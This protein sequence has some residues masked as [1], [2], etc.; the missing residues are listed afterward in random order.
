MKTAFD[1]IEEAI[2][3]SGWNEDSVIA[4]LCDYI[5]NQQAND[6]FQDFIVQRIADEETAGDEDD[7]LREEDFHELG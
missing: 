6:A 4:V 1:I 3:L 5:D 2:P 7:L